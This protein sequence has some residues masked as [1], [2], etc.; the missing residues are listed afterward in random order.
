MRKQ[1]CD[2]MLQRAVNPKM[3]FLTGD[4]GFMAL[5]PLQK[6][7]GERFI[8]AGIAEQNM[9]SVAA[10]MSKTGMEIWVYSIAPFCYARAFEQIRNDVAFHGLPVKIVGNGGGYGYGVQGPTHHAIEDYGVMLTLPGMQVCIPVFDEDLDDAVS[11]IVNNNS[12]TYLRLG[13]GEQPSG[14]QIPSFEPWRLLIEGRGPVVVACGPLASTY[15]ASVQ[16]MPESIRPNLWAVSV[17]PLASTPPNPEM[18]RQLAQSGKLIVAEE[19]VQRGGLASELIL[20]MAE[21]GLSPLRFTHLY[22]KAHRYERYGSQSYLRIQSKLD[23]LSLQESL[24]SL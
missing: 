1:F 11:W 17:L 18:L 4:L 7:L 9:L 19:H 2:A 8:N 22:A 21:R 15:I 6:A 20:W 24:N 3:A 5:E 23:P 16:A 13:R 10:A 12:P 14:F